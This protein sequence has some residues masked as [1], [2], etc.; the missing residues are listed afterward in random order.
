VSPATKA[1][2]EASIALGAAAGVDAAPAL[3]VNGR[4]LPPT[5]VPYDTLKRIVAYQAQLDGVSV[6]VQPTLSNLK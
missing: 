6:H 1:D 5:A 4:I 3:V 2:V